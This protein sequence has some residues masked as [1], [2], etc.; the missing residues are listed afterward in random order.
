MDWISDKQVCVCVCVCIIRFPFIL[1][2][3]KIEENMKTFS[4][5]EIER[6]SWNLAQK[7][8]LLILNFLSNFSLLGISVQVFSFNDSNFMIFNIFQLEMLKLTVSTHTHKYRETEE[9]LN[10]LKNNFSQIS[11]E[12]SE[13]KSSIVWGP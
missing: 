13:F 4:R 5:Q 12:E 3:S 9:K 7:S 8:S 10:L 6:E 1:F 11:K 2:K